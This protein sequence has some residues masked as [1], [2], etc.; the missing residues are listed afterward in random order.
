MN[1]DIPNEGRIYLRIYADFLR[2]S[3]AAAMMTV[4][5]GARLFVSFRILLLY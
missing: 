2:G 5:G 3:I 1:D 4:A